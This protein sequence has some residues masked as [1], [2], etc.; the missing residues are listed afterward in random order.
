MNFSGWENIATLDIDSVADYILTGQRIEEFSPDNWL[1]PFIGNKTENLTILDFGCGVGRNTFGMEL[2][3]SNWIPTGYDNAAMIGRT[4]EYKKLKYSDF[5]F[6][7]VKFQHM[8]DILKEQ[9]FD[10]IF[11]SLVLQHIP[12][13]DLKIYIEDFKKMT[14]KLIVCG[15]R[16]NDDKQRS[17]WSIIEECGLVPTKFYL[18]LKETIYS[19]AGDPD[20]HNIGIYCFE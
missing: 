4:E 16:F 13:K 1:F 14:K 20:E 8:W 9:T 10:C 11:C 7:K 2:Y 17:T 5:L 3:S 18:G 6:T 19:S 12:E 15:R